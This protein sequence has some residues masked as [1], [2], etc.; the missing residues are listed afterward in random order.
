[1]DTPSNDVQSPPRKLKFLDATLSTI[2]MSIGLRWLAVAAAVGVAAIPLWLAGLM[3]FFI[4]LTIATGEL[5]SRFEGE[6]GI[7]IWTRASFGPLAGFLCG[8]FYWFSNLPYFAGILYFV[9][10]LLLTATGADQHNT[11][12]FIGVSVALLIAL[13]VVQFAGLVVSKWLPNLGTAGAWIIFAGIAAIAGVLFAR[14]QSAT[15]FATSSYL[16]PLNFDGAILFGVIIGAYSGSEAVAFLRDEIEG[17]VRTILRV[18]L[19]VGI[20]GAIFYVLGT[21]AMLVILPSSQMSRLGGFADVL[22]AIFTRIGLP[23]LEPAALVFL[24][25][26]LIGGFTGW[27]SAATRLLMSVG[28]DHYLPGVFARRSSKTGAPVVA[29]LFQAALIVVMLVLG[30]A[31][32]SAAVAYDFLV[33]MGILTNTVCYVFLFAAYLRS[34]RS[35]APDGGWRP[36]GGRTAGMLIG[37]AGM[38]ASIVGIACTL[39]PG[40]SDHAP[41]QTFLKLVVSASVLTAAGLVLFWIGNRKLATA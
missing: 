25:A 13:V 37:A 8:L 14:G 24:A 36:A 41:L 27:F 2:V 28:E 21:A 6:G 34:T 19:F 7:Y 33:S 26:S 10:G 29:I 11:S 17:G 32:A 35:A 5:T 12:L 16:P 40:A 39:A 9:S 23:G 20:A 30:Q 15:Q 4:P 38:V 3:L 1:M 31:G 18:L 22:H